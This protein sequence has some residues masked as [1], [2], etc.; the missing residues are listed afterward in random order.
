MPMTRAMAW[1]AAE[2]ILAL[3]LAS[4]ASV[5]VEEGTERVTTI[6]MRIV[7]ET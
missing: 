2:V 4:C 6:G 3:A 1:A 7:A 5:S